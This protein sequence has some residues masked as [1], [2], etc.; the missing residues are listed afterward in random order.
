M[1]DIFGYPFLARIG[2][3]GF[4]LSRS[5]QNLHG[6][7]PQN[8]AA[9]QMLRGYSTRAAT[10]RWPVAVFQNLIDTRREFLIMLREHFCH[11]ERNRRIDIHSHAVERT[12]V[13]RNF[14]TS[15]KITKTRKLCGSCGAL[16]CGTCAKMVCNNCTWIH[17]FYRIT[18]TYSLMLYVAMVCG[19]K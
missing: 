19:R 7:D 8:P 1:T 2:R 6:S 4:F 3:I 11:G 15:S 12:P 10:R 18:F 9:D 5:D 17:T 13:L 14:A 16:V